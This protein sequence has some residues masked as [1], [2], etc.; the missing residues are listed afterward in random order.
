[1]D[2]LGQKN[3]SLIAIVLNCFLSLKGWEMFK[4]NTFSSGELSCLFGTSYPTFLPLEV[5]SDWQFSSLGLRHSFSMIAYFFS[6]IMSL[7]IHL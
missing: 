5:V 4:V 6:A 3:S 2:E 1:M 7:M